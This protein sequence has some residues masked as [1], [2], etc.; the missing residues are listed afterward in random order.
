MSIG[1]NEKTCEIL[2]KPVASFTRRGPSGSYSYH[3][4]SDVIRRLNEAFGHCWSSEKLESEV[5]EDQVL[6]LVSLTVYMD[7]DTISHQGYGSADV[8]RRNSDKKI[9]SIGNDYKSAFTNA[10]KK[11]AEQFGI[12]LG[13]EEEETAAPTKAYTA[14]PAQARP[15]MAQSMSQ[16]MQASPAAPTA[17]SRPPMARPEAMAP[18]TMQA[19]PN[20]MGGGIRATAAAAV[21]NAVDTSEE[22]TPAAPPVNPEPMAKPEVKNELISSVQA[23]AL[24][25]LADMK[26]LTESEIVMGA[27]PESGKVSFSELLRTEASEVIKYA[28]V[29]PQGDA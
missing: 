26:G 17:G 1:L 14:P 12:G 27:L 4:G 7:G 25:R 29:Q 11:A 16:P 21:N 18:R 8:K 28:N 6:M 9:V 24:S 23:H 10:L 2:R 22:S 20:G 19:R 13:D 3:K 15:P 5:V